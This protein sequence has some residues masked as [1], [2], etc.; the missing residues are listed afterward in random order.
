MFLDSMSKLNREQ[1]LVVQ[2]FFTM[3]MQFL[4]TVVGVIAFFI[5]L[6]RLF[7][8]KTVFDSVKYTAIDGLLGG[9]IFMSYKYFF[10]AATAKEKDK[11]PVTIPETNAN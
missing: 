9:S 3:G 8:A 6:F 1:A 11:E 2:I 5:V 4:L 10:P 7:E